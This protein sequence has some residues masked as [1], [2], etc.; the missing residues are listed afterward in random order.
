[1]GGGWRAMMLDFRSHKI[2]LWGLSELDAAR[3][4]AAWQSGAWLALYN[5]SRGG[6][7]RLEVQGLGANSLAGKSR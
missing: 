3:L 2:S 6:V 4:P 5:R 7:W 1:M